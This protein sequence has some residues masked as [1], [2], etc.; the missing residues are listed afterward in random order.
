MGI[1]HSD[2]HFHFQ[3]ACS[4]RTGCARSSIHYTADPSSADMLLITI[5][6][7]SQLLFWCVGE[8]EGD[9]VDRNEN[10]NIARNLVANLTTHE[11]PDLFDLALRKRLHTVRNQNPQWELK[12]LGQVSREARFSKP[13]EVGKLFVTRLATL[14]KKVGITTTCRVCAAMRNDSSAEGKRCTWR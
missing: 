14:L 12:S 2:D 5:M 4:K 7:V 10:L 8:R 6:S 3:K 13:L 11:T 1:Q 9:N